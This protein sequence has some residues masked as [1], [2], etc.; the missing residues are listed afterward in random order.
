MKTI[1]LASS[2]AAGLRIFSIVIFL[3]FCASGA[4]AAKEKISIDSVKVRGAT[5]ELAEVEIVGSY[6]GSMGK[7]I[8]AAIARSRDGAVRSDGYWPVFF[9]VGENVKVSARISAPL[10]FEAQRTDLLMVGFY[11]ADK[12][13]FLW[14]SLEWV[15]VWPELS[16]AQYRASKIRRTESRPSRSWHAILETLREEDFAALD[17]LIDRWSSPN[18]RDNDGKSPLGSFGD[19]L[20]S[21]FSKRSRKSFQASGATEDA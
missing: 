7:L 1:R 9:P 13:M 20:S 11:K 8:M 17:A 19:A 4:W 3:H 2:S 21:A 10:G 5:P 18:E 6:D 12:P 15:H 14:R 16:E